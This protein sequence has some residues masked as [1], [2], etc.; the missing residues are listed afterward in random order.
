MGKS[1]D[2]V[3]ISYAGVDFVA[4][5]DPSLIFQLG[6]HKGG[7]ITLVGR[8]QINSWQGHESVQVMIDYIDIADAPKDAPIAIENEPLVG[9][10]NANGPL[11]WND[12]I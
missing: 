9:D 12:L 10:N 8:P 7:V 5:K 3:K 11:S 2:S 4:F 1:Q 6:Q